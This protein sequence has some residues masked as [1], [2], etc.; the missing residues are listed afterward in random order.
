MKLI[1]TFLSFCLFN[2]SNGQNWMQSQILDRKFNQAVSN[3]NGG[4]FTISEKIILE[5]LSGDPGVY[6]EPS[7]LLLLKNEIALNK[8]NKA[9]DSANKFLSEFSESDYLPNVLESLGDLYVNE[10]KYASAYRMYHQALSHI[11]ID[12]RKIQEKLFYLSKIQLPISLIDELMILSTNNES[13]NIHLITRANSELLD[14]DPDGAAITLS[15]IN[16]ESL[17]PI[18][19]TFYNKLLEASYRPSLNLL[20]V[21]LILPLSGKGS[22]IANAFLKGFYAGELSLNSENQRL[23]TIVMDSKSIDINAVKISQ[24]LEEMNLVSGIVC[25]LDAPTTLAVVSALSST[26]IPVILSNYRLNDLSK[27]YK[28]VFLTHST[29]EID[30]INTARYAINNLGLD[31]LAIIAP[32]NIYGETQVDA[33]IKEV[34]RLGANVVATEWYSGEPKNLQRQFKFIRKIGF[35]LLSE[36]KSFDEALGMEIDSLDALFDVSVDDYFDLPQTNKKKMTSSDSSKVILKTIQGLYLPIGSGEAEFLGTQIPM[37]NLDTRVF[38]NSNWQDLKVLKKENIGPHLKG[39]SILTD[40]YKPANDTV[41]YNSELQRSYF[42]GYNTAQ[43]LLKLS[44]KENNRNGLYNS[45]IGENFINGEG[46]FFVP[47]SINKNVNSSSQILEF[48]GTSFLSKGLFH[49]DSLH[50]TSLENQ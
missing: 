47:S 25:E 18:Y 4:K 39:L 14:G 12:G 15:K 27:I 43:L 11:S 48:N 44:I 34:D 36:E 38:G 24:N 29:I 37:Y 23:S 32:A 31:S 10:T 26:D 33:F 46:F 42:R 30:A 7:L 3:Y 1:I 21:G 41:D 19:N 50:N 49:S 8:P 2:I 20:T 28:K 45:L 16:K 6:K 5:I 40:F 9:K 22:E 35:D 17:N 13:K